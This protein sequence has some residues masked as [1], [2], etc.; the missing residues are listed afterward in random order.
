MKEKEILDQLTPINQNLFKQLIDLRNQL[1]TIFRKKFNRTLPFNELLSNRW[2]K[3]KGLSFGEGTSVYDDVLVFGDV[4]IGKNT[5]VG[6][7][8]I[9]DGSG[10]LKIGSNCSISAGVQIYSHNTVLWAVSG[11]IEPYSF[12]GTTIGSNCF[13]GPQSVIENGVVIGDHCIVGA[14][15]FVNRPVPDFSIVAGTPAKVIGKVFLTDEGKVELK[16]SKTS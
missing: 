13:I 2:E 15:S 12:E 8:V 11:G 10:G 7:T 4:A 9:L 1:T 5:W 16:Y 3:A 6:P 14:K